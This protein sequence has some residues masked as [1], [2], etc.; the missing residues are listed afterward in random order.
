MGD[1]GAADRHH[2]LA[3]KALGLED[4]DQV[5]E[6][7]DVEVL[8]GDHLGDQDSV[9]L[10]GDR[11]RYQRLVGHLSAHVDGVDHPVALQAVV[12]VEALHVHDGV[13]AHGMGVGAGAG[14]YDRE[15]APEFL[16]DQVV[17]LSHVHD[18]ELGAGDVDAGEVD[19]LG[20]G[21]VHDEE[22][23]RRVDGLHRHDRRIL[24]AHAEHEAL[25]GLVGFGARRNRQGE[26]HLDLAVVERVAIGTDLG[27]IGFPGIGQIA[28]RSAST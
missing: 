20:A 8:L 25:G 2:H 6:G 9:G 24:E 28:H 10:F 1:S 15:L 27:E 19:G 4:L 21:G 14:A 3:A 5:G 26:A 17:D 23:H 18:R 22:G 16:F 12:A 7:H 13:D 11:P